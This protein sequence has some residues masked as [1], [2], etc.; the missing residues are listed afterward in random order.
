MKNVLSEQ[1]VKKEV[2]SDGEF[3][4]T[5]ELVLREGMRT[6]DFRLP[7]YSVKVSMTDDKG[8]KSQKVVND[9]FSNREHAFSFFERLVTNLA[10]PIDLGYV[11]EDEVIN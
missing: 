1:V 6:A 2:R 4:Y 10:T 8:R 3:F 5:Y 7:L 11:V 9:I